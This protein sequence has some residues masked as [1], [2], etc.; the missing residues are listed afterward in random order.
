[1]QEVP[2]DLAL[3]VPHTHTHPESRESPSRLPAH[4]G[5]LCQNAIAL[6]KASARDLSPCLAGDGDLGDAER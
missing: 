1:M 6:P 2:T 5:A 3:Q 4:E